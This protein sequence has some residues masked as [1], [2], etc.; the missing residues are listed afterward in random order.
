MWTLGCSLYELL[1]ERPL[2]EVFNADQDHAIAEM[3]STLGPL[4]QRWW[5]QWHKKTDFFLEDGSWKQDT[6][7]AHAPYDRPL[8]ERLV[9]MGRML[10]DSNQPRDLGAEELQ[11][12]HR[13]L[14]D[15][16]TYEP[17]KRITSSDVLQSAWMVNWA[18]PSFRATQAGS[19]TY[20][21]VLSL[22]KICF[23]IS[24]FSMMFLVL[25]GAFVVFT[26]QSQ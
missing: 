20:I 25:N 10:S 12:I 26:F 2:F 17:S 14:L 6:H 19:C 1:G 4:P 22:F 23:V 5:E 24:M 16:L 9:R 3:I 21:V 11:Q 8:R 18:Y 13:L 15:M 7:R